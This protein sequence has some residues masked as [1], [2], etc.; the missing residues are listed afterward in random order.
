MSLK[1]RDRR[2]FL[3]SFAGVYR[4]SKE[5]GAFLFR[6]S[7][8]GKCEPAKGAWDPHA[9]IAIGVGFATEGRGS[10]WMGSAF[11]RLALRTGVRVGVEGVDPTNRVNIESCAVFTTGKDGFVDIELGMSVAVDAP[12]SIR[13]S[14]DPL[15]A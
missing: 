13:A 7:D 1:C 15:G 4:D 9:W 12:V 6:D 5:A 3:G 2:F 11:A 10:I 8:D 14:Q